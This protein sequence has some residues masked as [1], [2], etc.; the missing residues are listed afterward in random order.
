MVRFCSKL[1]CIMQDFLHV[2][3]LQLFMSS[4][5]EQYLITYPRSHQRQSWFSRLTEV[6][7]GMLSLHPSSLVF[8]STNDEELDNKWWAKEHSAGWLGR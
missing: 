6:C 8:T 3:F 7:I 5:V 1:Q 4:S 2:T